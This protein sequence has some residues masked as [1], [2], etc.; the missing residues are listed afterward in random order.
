ME[1][2]AKQRR[3]SRRGCRAAGRAVIVSLDVEAAHLR[4]VVTD[5]LSLGEVEVIERDAVELS[6]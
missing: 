6:R 1:D 2:E 5:M 4:I 3:A